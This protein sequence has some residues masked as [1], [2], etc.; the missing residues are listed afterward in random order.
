MVEGDAGTAL[1]H[2]ITVETP[3]DG[4]S[5]HAASGPHQEGLNEWAVV[6]HVFVQRLA[7]LKYFGFTSAA[8]QNQVQVPS[9]VTQGG[10]GVFVQDPAVGTE[11]QLPAPP[12]DRQGLPLQAI[13]VVEVR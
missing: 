9:H 6:L 12:A 3:S 10:L 11:R 2:W 7:M 13:P 4:V 8:N 5:L 1:L